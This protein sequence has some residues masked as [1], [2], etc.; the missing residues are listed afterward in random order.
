MN[1][2]AR[3]LVIHG[4]VVIVIGLIYGFAY[5]AVIVSDSSEATQAAWKLAHL[6]GLLNGMLIAIVGATYALVNPP[7]VLE[8]WVRYPLLVTAYANILAP[9]VGALSGHR[10]LEMGGALAN[11]A[12][13]LIFLVGVIAVF[14]GLGTYLY[15]LIRYPKK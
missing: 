7:N 15:C 5:G 10:G 2:S 9:L 1:S 6:E 13:Y 14:V 11:Q 8:R 12:V 4:I 3:S